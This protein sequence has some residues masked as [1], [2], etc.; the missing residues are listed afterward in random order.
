MQDCSYLGYL[1]IAENDKNQPFQGKKGQIGI[2]GGKV[3]NGQ[4]ISA[5]IYGR[6]LIQKNIRNL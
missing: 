4:N 6:S 3:R 2:I 1:L 5:I